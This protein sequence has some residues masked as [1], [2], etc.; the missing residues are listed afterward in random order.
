MSGLRGNC[1]E[2]HRV[3]C[4]VKMIQGT[5]GY[6]AMATEGHR[7]NLVSMEK[8][9]NTSIGRWKDEKKLE[10]YLLIF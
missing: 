6:T 5:V 9:N 7:P 10:K 2:C 8:I 4:H 3:N 1:H